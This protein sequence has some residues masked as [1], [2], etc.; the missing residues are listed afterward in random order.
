[1][2]RGSHRVDGCCW[3]TWTSWYTSFIRNC[4]SSTSS[5]VCGVMRPCSRR[6]HRTAGRKDEPHA[7][8][9][10]DRGGARAVRRGAARGAI[11]RAEQSAV[12]G[13]RVPDHPDRA[14]RDLL[15]S[16]RTNGGLGRRA[17]G[18]AVVRPPVAHPA[19]P[20]PGPE[21]DHFVRVAVRLP[22]DQHDQRGPGRG[23]GRLHRVLQAPDGTAL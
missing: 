18:R 7:T 17:Y 2:S 16:R 20:V 23:D 21:A 12:P 14:L 6:A 9:W 5:N 3:T 13:L 22:A 4:G 10:R 15:L 8:H 19:P 11:L 1:M